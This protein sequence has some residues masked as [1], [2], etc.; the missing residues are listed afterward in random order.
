MQ[1]ANAIWFKRRDPGSSPR[2]SI[3]VS[4]TRR[5]SDR[6]NYCCLAELE[7]NNLPSHLFA[8][9]SR[10]G[11]GHYLECICG[12]LR[13]GEALLSQKVLDCSTISE[14]HVFRHGI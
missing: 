14:Q 6:A 2:S 3:A 11:A 7:A 5:S 13:A 4:C 1:M 8:W 9:Q 10:G 12:T